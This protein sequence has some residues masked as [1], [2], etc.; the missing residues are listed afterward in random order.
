MRNFAVIAF[1]I[2]LFVAPPARSQE[3]RALVPGVPAPRAQIQDLAW[4]AGEWT[5]TGIGGSAAAEVYS[6]PMAGQIAGHFVQTNARGISFFEIVSIAEEAGTLVFRL[7][8]F[9]AD[10]TG[11]EERNDVRSFRLVAVEPDVWFFDGLTVRRD[12]ADGLITAVMV[13]RP[14]TPDREFLFRYRRRR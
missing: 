3:T 11:W 5:G 12:G 1:L 2:G 4:L 7:K 14:G 6:T 13:H 8:H 10:L 9:N